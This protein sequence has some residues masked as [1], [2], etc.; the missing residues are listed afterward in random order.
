MHIYIPQRVRSHFGS[1]DFRSRLHALLLQGASGHMSHD[2]WLDDAVPAPFGV[3][4]P[5]MIDFFPPQYGMD[6]NLANR[7]GMPEVGFMG[8]WSWQHFG[9]HP[10]A[11]WGNPHDG[12]SDDCWNVPQTMQH[13]GRPLASGSNLARKLIYWLDTNVYFEQIPDTRLGRETKLLKLWRVVKE[14]SQSELPAYLFQEMLQDVVLLALEDRSEKDR[15]EKMPSLGSKVVQKCLALAGPSEKEQ[16]ITRLNSGARRLLYHDSGCFVVSQVLQE[17]SASPDESIVAA[18]IN[19]MAAAHKAEQAAS[20]RDNLFNSMTHSHANHS[21]KMWVQLLAPS[22][23]YAASRTSSD[24]HLEAILSVVQEHLLEL[25]THC[26]GVRTVNS[27]LEQF[28]STDQR[29]VR[30]I[31]EKLVGETHVLDNLIRNEFANFA[32]SIAVDLELDRI[33]Q[34]MC[35]HFAEYALDRYGNYVLQKCVAS[36]SERWLKNFTGAYI[37]NKSVIVKDS[38]TSDAVRR[39]LEKALRKKG[40]M[41]D[42]RRL[43]QETAQTDTCRMPTQYEPQYPAWSNYTSNASLSTNQKRIRKMV[44]RAAEFIEGVMGQAGGVPKAVTKNMTSLSVS[45]EGEPVICVF[46]EQLVWK[47]AARSHLS[48]MQK[49]DAIDFASAHA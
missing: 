11:A 28:G 43:G 1:S 23:N 22:E 10:A 9:Q 38:K 33:C 13:G 14:S 16:I 46:H 8:P 2:L 20:Y 40:L 19:F 24:G 36:A 42:L 45:V 27:L 15:R 29:K 25:V 21:L 4:G 31:L 12:G 3:S 5:P 44:H 30:P 7:F 26:Q 34:A 41:S 18:A 39:S 47:P 48:D 35:D 17:G 6:P 37:Q 32:I 49:S